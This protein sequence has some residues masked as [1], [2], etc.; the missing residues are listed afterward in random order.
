[1]QLRF[2]GQY[3]A[4]EAKLRHELGLAK[5]LPQMDRRILWMR[6]N[7]GGALIAQGKFSAAA[8]TYRE[9]S[10]AIPFMAWIPKWQNLAAL[11]HDLEPVHDR[12][13]LELAHWGLERSMESFGKDDPTTEGFQAKVDQLLNRSKPSSDSG[14]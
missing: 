13:A 11:L 8:T 10:D 12:T 9:S 7:L 5:D 2:D 1:M 6:E 3:A 4:A 14:F